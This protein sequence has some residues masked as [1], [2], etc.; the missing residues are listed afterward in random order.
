[1]NNKLINITAFVILAAL[2]LGFGAALVFNPALLDAVWQAFLG[3][4]LIGQLATALLTLPVLAGLWIWQMDW[5]LLL[6]LALVIGLALATVT[7]F[8]PMKPA[9]RPAAQPHE[10]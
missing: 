5:P 10:L 6:R 1:M 3:W 4:P 9:A 8:N 7:T 2:W